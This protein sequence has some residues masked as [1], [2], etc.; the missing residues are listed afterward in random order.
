MRDGK[1]EGYTFCIQ[2]VQSR[3][4]GLCYAF[5]GIFR[6]SLLPSPPPGRIVSV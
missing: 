3:G 1:I 6:V 2:P 4:G 5:V